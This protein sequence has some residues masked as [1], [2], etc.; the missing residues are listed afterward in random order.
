[1]KEG[2]YAAG[3]REAIKSTEARGLTSTL[4]QQSLRYNRDEESTYFAAV[5]PFR[6]AHS[7]LEELHLTEPA[8][9]RSSTAAR[10]VR[11]EE[12]VQQL[13]VSTGRPDSA[14]ENSG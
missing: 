2:K 6:R 1:M 8:V 5:R 9:V 11:L 14:E 7:A 10:R 13:M 3:L 12:R 4:S